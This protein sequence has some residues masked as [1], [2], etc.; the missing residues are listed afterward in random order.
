MTNEP[1]RIETDDAI[2]NFRRVFLG[3]RGQTLMW[4]ASYKAYGV[5]FALAVV[6]LIIVVGVLGRPFLSLSVIYSLG[7][8]IL[9]TKLIMKRTDS[10]TPLRALPGMATATVK[11]GRGPKTPHA[12]RFDASAVRIVPDPWEDSVRTQFYADRHLSRETA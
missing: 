8:C 6:D 12:Y 11:A 9:I 7:A 3:P 2:R 4:E 1:L 5:F 10:E